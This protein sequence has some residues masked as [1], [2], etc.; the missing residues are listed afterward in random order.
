MM[1]RQM[2]RVAI[3][4]LVAVSMLVSCNNTDKGQPSSATTSTPA[5]ASMDTPPTTTAMVDG[6]VRLYCVEACQRNFVYQFSDLLFYN[7]AADLPGMP[8]DDDMRLILAWV[9]ASG[10]LYVNEEEIALQSDDVQLDAAEF[11][12]YYVVTANTFLPEP[13]APEAPTANLAV[14]QSPAEPIA[15]VVLFTSATGRPDSWT[16]LEAAMTDAGD[17]S[18]TLTTAQFVFGAVGSNTQNTLVVLDTEISGPDTFL[19]CRQHP[20]LGYW[21]KYCIGRR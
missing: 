3:L 9:P 6:G 13:A 4:A 10:R 16:Q 2:R 17:D 5:T 1:W 15:E 11:W 18:T 8:I 7:G 12:S 21:L 19:R 14:V 20:S